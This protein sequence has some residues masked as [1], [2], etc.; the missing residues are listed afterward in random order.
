MFRIRRIYDDAVPANREAIK[1]VAEIFRAQFAAARPA[2]IETLPE[3]LRDPLQRGLRAILYVAENASHKVLGF[4]LVLHEPRL[5]FCYLDYLASAKGIVDRG[6]GGALY[7]RVR[8]DAVALGTKG[9]FLECLPDDPAQCP[10]ETQLKQNRARIRFYERYGARVIENTE[11]EAPVS[12]QDTGMP[13]LVY[14]GLGHDAPLGRAFARQAVAAILERKYAYLCPPEYVAKVVRSFRDDPVHLRPVRKAVPAP[15]PI[16]RR[17]TYLEPISL[18]VNRKHDIHHVRE[19][20]Y[21]EAPVRIKSILAEIEPTGLF[22]PREARVFGE[23]HITAVHRRDFVEYLRKACAEVPAGR[24]VYPYVFPI[25]NPLRPPRELSIRAGYYCIDTFTP[26]NANAFLAAKGAVNCALTAADEILGGRPLAY[27]L[28]RPPG[29]HAE[30]RSFGGFCYFNNAAIAAQYLV[31]HGKVAILDIDYHH[32]NG[33]QDI[34]YER[35]DVLTVSIHGHPNFAYPYF[36]GFADERGA[37]PGLGFNVNLPLGE[38]QDGPQYRLALE[39]ALALV[40]KFQP[41]FL[42]VALGLDTAKGDPTGSWRLS[43]KDLEANGR[44]IGALRMPTVVVQEG[45]YRTRTLGTNAKHFF[46]G[47]VAGRGG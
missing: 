5:K 27:A 23:R 6:I 21:V 33:Q 34:F 24:S 31:P 19:R 4:A 20:G 47:L 1:Q 7:E 32:G 11:Y 17:P 44:M 46:Q 40:R 43:A 28:V 10:D 35:S 8:Q 16:E 15:A 39:K 42:I 9:L 18:I 25:R 14:D 2:D 3:H 30:A 29:H 36:T 26:L 12:P 37:G 13:H 41:A 38:V 22:A 45:G